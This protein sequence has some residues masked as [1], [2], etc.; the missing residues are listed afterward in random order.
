MMTKEIILTGLMMLLLAACSS[1]SDSSDVVPEPDN[2]NGND[3]GNSSYEPSQRSIGFVGAFADGEGGA[4]SARATRGAM[5]RA[6]EPE[7]GEGEFTNADLQASGFGVYCWYTGSSI[8]NPEY[9]PDIKAITQEILMLNQ[10][11]EYKNDLW[12]Y[13]PSKYWPLKDFPSQATTMRV[14]RPAI[15]GL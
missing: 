12:T 8:Y 3:S 5:R 2:G 7:P 13:S 11:V 1:S 10:K 14:I 4:A 6:G 15:N 9:N